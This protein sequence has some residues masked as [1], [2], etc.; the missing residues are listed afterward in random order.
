MVAIREIQE[1]TSDEITIKL[2]KALHGKQVEII[3]LA[4]ENAEGNTPALQKLLLNAPTLSDKD[5]Q[6]YQKAREWMAQ[7]NITEF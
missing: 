5:L 7:W 2:P 6:T 4:L 3:V 1:V